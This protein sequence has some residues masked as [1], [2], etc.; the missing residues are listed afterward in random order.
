MIN[1]FILCFNESILLPHTIKHYKKYLPSCNI[2]IYDN[3]STDNSVEIALSLGCKV[4]CWKEPNDMKVATKIR[5]NCWK[6][7]LDGWIIMAD[8]DEWLYITEEELLNE[9]NNNTTILNIKGI[10]MIGE[11]KCNFLNDIDLSLINKALDNTW[12]NKK[13]CF[14][15]NKIIDMNY[16]A[17]A[18]NCNPTGIVNYSS[19]IYIN[20][21]MNCLGLPYYINKMIKCYDRSTELRKHGFGTHYINDINLLTERYNS[22]VQSAYII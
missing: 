16:D 15:R 2:T 20:R 17:G 10:D 8:M 4:I 1:I 11:S 7:I 9:E 21:H 22:A 13:L 6:Y 5:D 19:N 18:H 14:Y 3:E 12:E